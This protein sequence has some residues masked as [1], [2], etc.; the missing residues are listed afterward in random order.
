MTHCRTHLKWLLV[1]AT[2]QIDVFI[3]YE[4]SADIFE[5]PKACFGIRVRTRGV[6]VPPE[7]LTHPLPGLRLSI[8]VNSRRI[9]YSHLLGGEHELLKKKVIAPSLL[10]GVGRDGRDTSAVV[11]E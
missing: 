5:L 7:R 8:Q 4:G 10:D 9:R 11:R 6:D 2:V 1:L 3:D